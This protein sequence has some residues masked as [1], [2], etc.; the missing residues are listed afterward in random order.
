[1]NV[2]RDQR[3]AKSITL[4]LYNIF[5]FIKNSRFECDPGPVQEVICPSGPLASWL[6]VAAMEGSRGL[7]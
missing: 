4:Y 1:M 2:V 7:G 3:G 6:V 5:E